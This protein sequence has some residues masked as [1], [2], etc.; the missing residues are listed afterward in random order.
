MTV[1]LQIFHQNAL[2]YVG[3]ILIEIRVNLGLNGEWLVQPHCLLSFSLVQSFPLTLI[4]PLLKVSKSSKNFIN[5]YRR[6]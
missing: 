4:V 2:K 1:H 5:F 3:K 6:Y